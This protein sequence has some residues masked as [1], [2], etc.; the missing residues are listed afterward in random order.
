[1]ELTVTQRLALIV[2]IFLI[3]STL[4]YHWTVGAVN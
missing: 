3:A 4:D 1:M 2:V